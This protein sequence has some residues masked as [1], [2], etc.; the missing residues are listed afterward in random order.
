MKT[1]EI[2]KKACTGNSCFHFSD[3]KKLI[4]KKVEPWN[5]VRVTFKIPRD[6]A[7]RLKQLAQQGNATLR[8]LGVLAVKI[9]DQNISLTIAGRNNERTQLVF[10]TADTLQATTPTVSVYNTN[11]P[12]LDELGPQGP[13]PSHVDTTSKNI[14]DYL[15]Q[16]PLL[17]DSIFNQQPGDRHLEGTMAKVN[18]IISEHGNGQHRT[19]QQTASQPSHHNNPSSSSTSVNSVSPSRSPV[20]TG[21]L[22]FPQSGMAPGLPPGMPPGMPPGAPRHALDTLPPPP[23]YPEGSSYMNNFQKLRF[24]TAGASPLLVNLLQNNPTF[25]SLLGAGRLPPALDPDQLQPPKKKRKPRKPKEKKNKGGELLSMPNAVITGT[26]T[27]VA[28]VASLS[29][30]HTTSASISHNL[31]PSVK[32]QGFQ[33]VS[34]AMFHGKNSQIEQSVPLTSTGIYRREECDTAGKI[35]NPVTGLLEPMDLSDTSPSKSDGDKHSPRSLAQRMPLLGDHRRDS[36]LMDIGHLTTLHGRTDNPDQGIPKQFTEQFNPHS[37]ASTEHNYKPFSSSHLGKNASSDSLK[38]K[39]YPEAIKNDLLTKGRLKN[40]IMPSHS[41]FEQRIP[42]SGDGQD[43]K[44]DMPDSKCDKLS[45]LEL[46]KTGDSK[47]NEKLPQEIDTRSIPPQLLNKPLLQVKHDSVGKPSVSPDSNGDSECSNIDTQNGP[48]DTGSHTGH[49]LDPRSYNNDSGVG[50]CSE[51]SDDTP[52]EPGDNDYKSGNHNS[53]ECAKTPTIDSLKQ[54]PPPNAKSMIV[55]YALEETKKNHKLVSERDI[56]NSVFDRVKLKSEKAEMCSTSQSQQ[57]FNNWAT[58]D[59][60]RFANNVEARVKQA[61]FDSIHRKS[62]KLS[63]S[64]ANSLHHA[65]EGQF[66]MQGMSEHRFC[67]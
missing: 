7:S 53:F 23:P 28:S 26:S 38:Q 52:S 55:G 41:K 59:P 61:V 39:R 8:E 48:A 35:I 5:S 11:S 19:F 50:S 51:R 37:V 10:R 25:S 20:A 36:K 2:E 64:L 4:L 18:N 1:N 42:K 49:H 62:P 14:A 65:V 15:R 45:A 57:L 30:T 16:G 54:A 21:G 33:N 34:Q 44:T 67:Y 60:L 22:K 63:T 29:S 56:L 3:K 9:E 43:V 40:D 27:E 6:A 24:D 32:E 47:K 17:L 58:D 66:P 46:T 13:G 12:S 31:N